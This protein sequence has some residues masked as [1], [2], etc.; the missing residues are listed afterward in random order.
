MRNICVRDAPCWDRTLRTCF[1]FECKTATASA[2]ARTRAV[3]AY[4][5]VALKIHFPV[6]KCLCMQGTTNVLNS[7]NTNRYFQITELGVLFDS[8]LN[9]IQYVATFTTQQF[10]TLSFVVRNVKIFQHIDAQELNFS[11]ITSK[12]EYYCTL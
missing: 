6:P 11:I 2:R 5:N 7:L 10:E 12:L 8:Q 3:S 4:T 1:R 9:L